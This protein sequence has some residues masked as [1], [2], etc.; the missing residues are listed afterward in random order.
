M[1]LV[2]EAE[3]V[4]GGGAGCVD[5]SDNE[6]GNRD[7]SKPLSPKDPFGCQLD[8]NRKLGLTITIGLVNQGWF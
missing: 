7:Q 8:G 5:I 4:G 2:G 1:V 3:A 6:V